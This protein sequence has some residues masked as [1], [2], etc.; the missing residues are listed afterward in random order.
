MTHWFFSRRVTGFDTIF[1]CPPFDENPSEKRSW[2]PVGSEHKN[3]QLKIGKTLHH[4]ITAVGGKDMLD[5]AEYVTRG[6]YT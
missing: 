2:Q 4:A 6:T 3:Q 5:A 1:R